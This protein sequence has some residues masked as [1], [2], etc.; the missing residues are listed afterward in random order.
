M[1]RMP[2][3]KSQSPLVKYNYAIALMLNGLSAEACSQFQE[4]VALGLDYIAYSEHG[5]GIRWA[6]KLLRDTLRN[7]Q[8]IKSFI[9]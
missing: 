1:Q 5:E 2:S 4:I 9:R 6:K 8:E 7:M 3:N